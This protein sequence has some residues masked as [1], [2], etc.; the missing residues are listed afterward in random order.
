MRFVR[1]VIG[2]LLVLP[3]AFTA[4]AAKYQEGDVADG[5]TIQGVISYNGPVKTRTVLPTK[6]KEVC[7]SPRKEALIQVGD[8][9][10]VKDSVVFIEGIPSGKPWGEMARPVINNIKCVFEPRVQVAKRGKVDILNSDAV[11]HNTH[12]YYGKQT[13]FNV[14]LPIKDAK[15]TKILRK[16][17]ELKTDCDA[18]GWMLGW[19][20]VV[21]NPYFMQTGDD[22][23]FTISDVPPGDYELSV[24]QEMLGVMKVAVSVKAGETTNIDIELGT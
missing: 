24:W 5:G 8:G 21:D 7:G 16:T 23:A 3:L 13:A 2:F 20:Y 10:A 19:V 12:G 4:H 14:A 1:I 6:D 22:G 15:V 17:G 18:H 11:L 9:G